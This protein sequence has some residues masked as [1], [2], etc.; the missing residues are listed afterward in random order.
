MGKIY[1]RDDGTCIVGQKCSCNN[2]I[3]TAGSSWFVLQRVSANVVR[4]L[5]K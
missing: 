2:G 1:V 5:Y 3:A 4:I